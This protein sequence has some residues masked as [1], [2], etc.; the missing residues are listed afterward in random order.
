M[1]SGNL[2]AD[3]RFEYGRMLREIG[4]PA[5]A[6]DVIAQALELAPAWPE[7][8][9]ALAE[10]LAEANRKA[11]AIAAYR[12]YLGLDPTDSMGAVIRLGLLDPAAVPTALPEAYVRRLFDDYAPRFDDALVERLAYRA[13]EALRA[14][15]DGLFPG[16]A[17]KAMLDLGCGTGLAGAAFRPVTQ[18]REGVDLSE[19]MVTEAKRKA[20]Y[21]HLAVGDMIAHLANADRRFD[22]IIAADVLVYLG[23][24]DG[25]FHAARQKIADDGIFAFTVQRTEAADFRLGQEHRYSH[26]RAYI[27]ACAK[28]AGFTVAALDDGAFRQEKGVDVPGLL[29]ILRPGF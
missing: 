3:R 20:I 27:T 25:L 10:A 26:S 5:G 16:R 17:Y 8:H 2:T 19:R 24:L 21:D 7:G 11:D 6:A 15:V 23:A 13:P 18:W 29:A 28:S 22:L 9:F 14:A 12:A 1:S 4:D